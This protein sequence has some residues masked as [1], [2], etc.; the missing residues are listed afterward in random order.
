VSRTESR[1]GTLLGPEGTGALAPPSVR[2]DVPPNGPA[3]AAPRSSAP[4]PVRCA[5]ARG[6]LVAGTARILRTA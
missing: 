1:P 6:D 3:Q 4:D 2:T 5:G